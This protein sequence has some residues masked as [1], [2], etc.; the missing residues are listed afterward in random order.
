MRWIS[1]HARI[2]NQAVDS[3]HPVGIGVLLRFGRVAH[4]THSTTR[5]EACAEGH[6]EEACPGRAG[7]DNNVQIRMRVRLNCGF[8]RLAPPLG[9]TSLSISR[10]C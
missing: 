4:H 5:N 8:G 1:Q 2:N 3:S 10:F 9:V 7:E 6:V